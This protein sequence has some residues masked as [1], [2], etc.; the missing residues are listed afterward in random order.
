MVSTKSRRRALPTEVNIPYPEFPV[1]A[2]YREV[3]SSLFSYQAASRFLKI[4]DLE[5]HRIL[6]SGR[7]TCLRPVG[8]V[9]DPT[10]RLQGPTPLSRLAVRKQPDIFCITLAAAYLID[11]VRSAICLRMLLLPEIPLARAFP[12]SLAP[13]S[14]RT[15]GMVGSV[16][17][18]TVK[19]FG[20]RP[21]MALPRLQSFASD[22]ASGL[23]VPIYEQ[24]IVRASFF[25]E[26]P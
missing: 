9:T 3:L 11:P 12:M 18:A 15:C 19:V 24:P 1:P 4:V 5:I 14:A 25:D 22:S 10:A 16:A 26:K 13:M 20:C 8:R 21:V 23:S 2:I 6:E 17:S 7:R